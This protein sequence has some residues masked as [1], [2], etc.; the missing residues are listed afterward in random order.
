MKSTA[1]RPGV[2]HAVLTVLILLEALT[3]FF[4]GFLHSG[5]R[6]SMD[7][8]VLQE[9]RIIPATIVESLCG[10]LHSVSAFAVATR[11]SWSWTASVLAHTISIGGVLLGMAALALGA[12][13]R[14]ELND[15]YHRI[16]LIVLV[17]ILIYLL[18]PAGKSA[19]GRAL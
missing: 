10:L 2:A 17:V 9:P 19:L 13:P 14:T 12:G 16:I 4:F 18:T 6:L 11:K 8:A 1:S 5:V 3:F 15:I 7:F